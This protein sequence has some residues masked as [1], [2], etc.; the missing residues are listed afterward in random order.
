MILAAAAAAVLA[1]G[2]SPKP[3]ARAGGQPAAAQDATYLAPPEPDIVR[4]DASGLVL[5][6]RGPAGGRVRLAQPNG[7]AVFAEVDRAGRWTIPLGPAD[8]P[9]IYGLSVSADGRAAQAQ[10]YVLVTP[11]GQGAIL[12][13]GASARR[14]DAV[15]QHGFRAID[16]DAGG[17]LE[18]ACAA[19][20]GATVILTLDGR[21]AAEGRADETG[22]YAVSLPAAGQPTVRPGKHVLEMQGDGFADRVSVATVPAAPLAQ[23]PLR[24]QLTPA[25]LRLDW[26]TPGGGVQ[27][28]LLAH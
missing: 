10:G 1:A 20:P 15:T 16:F 9:R 26:M 12:R 27:S 3:A 19:P 22:R 25:G 18:I 6:G 21:Q 5:A 23:G 28:T 24:S 13:A 17:G 14:F 11:R 7:Q 8:Q 2:C 4:V